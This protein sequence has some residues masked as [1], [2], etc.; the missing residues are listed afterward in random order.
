MG[1][2]D[3]DPASSEL[4]N[5]IVKAEVWIGDKANGLTFQWYGRV[6]LNP[7]YG[8]TGNKSNQEVWSQKLL[9]EYC[10]GIVTEAV[11]LTKT[12]PGYGWWDWMFL[13]WP[14]PLCITKGRIA[15]FKPEWIKFINGRV[16]V[17][18]PAGQDHR[19]K[20]ASSFW[21]LGPNAGRFKAIFSEFGRCLDSAVGDWHPGAM[22]RI[23]KGAYVAR[24]KGNE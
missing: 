17:V 22:K 8:K 10:G 1:G 21:Y 9:Y 3:L 19:S 5:E 20:A 2:I 4:A 24:G 12:V 7:P 15:F 23:E 11:L 13:N 16:V 14:G 18:P 6:F